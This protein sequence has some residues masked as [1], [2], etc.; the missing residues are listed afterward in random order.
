MNLLS[1]HSNPYAPL[2]GEATE[3]MLRL[4]P[5]PSHARQVC[6]LAL[7]LFEL[8]E[9]L[10]SLGLEERTILEAAALLHDI[11]WS[12]SGTRHHK[13]AS[14]LI[15]EHSWETAS[16]TQVL[17]IAAV[18][19]YH[20]K[21]HPRKSHSVFSRL[22]PSSRDAVGRLAALL[23]VADGLDRSHGNRVVR[24]QAQLDEGCCTLLVQGSGACSAELWA[25]NRKRGL[26]E[27]VFGRRLEI[28]QEPGGEA[29]S[30]PAE[31]S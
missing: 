11:G 16:P 15:L 12:I 31:K 22:D 18:A 13:H 24:I 30:L 1:P 20:R 26:W 2:I 25:A 14:R 29:I 10:H 19:R 17:Q 9:P 4:D 5:E 21:A 6:R 8:M 27:E 23:R 3:L 28:R 7:Q